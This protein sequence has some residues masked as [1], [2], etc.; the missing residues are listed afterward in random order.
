M[1]TGDVKV[2]TRIGEG[3]LYMAV[4]FIGDRV[5]MEINN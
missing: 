2:G 4:I 3:E 5:T 1:K